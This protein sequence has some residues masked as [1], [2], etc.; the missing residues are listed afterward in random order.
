MQTT[1]FLVSRSDLSKSRFVHNEAQPLTSGQVRLQVENFA[2]TANNVSYALMGEQ[3]GYWSFFP[4]PD[5]EGR[6]PVWGYGRVVETQHPDIQLNER[7][8][9][10]LPMS[11]HLVV[12]PGKVTPKSISDAAPHRAA[13]S[14]F[15]NDYSRLSADAM[16]HPNREDARMLY[17]PLFTTSHLIE[18]TFADAD[19]LGAKTLV[20]TSASS[21]TAMALAL[22]TGRRNPDISV[23]GVTSDKNKDFVE[24][25]GIYDQVV[26]Y[27]ALSSIPQTPS[28]FVDFAGDA[29]LIG[30]ILGRLGADCRKAY[31]VGATHWTRVGAASEDA[32]VGEAPELFF[33]PSVA[34]QRLE[35]IGA[36]AY[37][38]E[39]AQAWSE[40]LDQ[41]AGWIQVKHLSGEAAVQQTWAKLLAGEATP[42]EGLILSLA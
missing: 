11:S 36:A 27:D 32:P 31:T 14:P 13:M 17:G 2:L 12:T 38:Q 24:G 40:F 10:Y 39:I 1:D 25:L 3:M 37:G 18:R 5:G 15:Y 29:A 41:S 16:H 22:M 8:Y 23:L 28:V 7:L 34:A 6:P 30:K 42:S 26:T 33:A 20:A 21:K 35:A 19:W 9:G 4:A